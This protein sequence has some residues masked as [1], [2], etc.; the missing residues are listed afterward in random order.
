[1]FTKKISCHVW[2][3]LYFDW[4]IG[5]HAINGFSRQSTDLASAHLLISLR[6]D[7]EPSCTTGTTPRSLVRGGAFRE[8]SRRYASRSRRWHPHNHTTPPR[9]REAHYGTSLRTLRRAA[10]SAARVLPSAAPRRRM[11]PR[12]TADRPPTLRP[13]SPSL[14][15]VPTLQ[16]HGHD[17]PYERSNSAGRRALPQG[18]HRQR[19][20]RRELPDLGAVA[21][22]A[23]LPPCRRRV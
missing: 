7:V 18:Q 6:C 13:S 9:P 10:A 14:F 22:R 11:C 5:N 1:M 17:A 4:L 15:P 3:R 19:S 23:I 12:C 20:R 8:R 21:Q 16:S 2:P